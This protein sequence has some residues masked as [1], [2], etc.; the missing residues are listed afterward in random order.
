MVAR[1]PSKDGRRSSTA[2]EGLSTFVGPKAF[3][4]RSLHQMAAPQGS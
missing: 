1:I 2:P 4:A 3:K